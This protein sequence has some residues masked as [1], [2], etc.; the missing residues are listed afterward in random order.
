MTWCLLQ[1]DFMHL[2]SYDQDLADR[3]HA[4]F[5]KYERALRTALNQFA[6][7]I[8]PQQD[9]SVPNPDVSLPL[10]TL[11]RKSCRLIYCKHHMLDAFSCV[12]AQ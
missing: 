5:Y 12:H 9:A 2:R 4:E 1:I 10:L 8:I 11:Q 6:K 3:V 7:K